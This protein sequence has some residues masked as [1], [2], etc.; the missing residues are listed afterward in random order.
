[1]RKVVKGKHLFEIW[2]QRGWDDL[3][4]YDV[5]TVHKFRIIYCPKPLYKKLHVMSDPFRAHWGRITILCGRNV[6]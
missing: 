2:H 5:I 3:P 4:I 1:M 6:K